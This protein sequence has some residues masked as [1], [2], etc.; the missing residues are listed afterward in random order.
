MPINKLQIQTLK[1]GLMVAGIKE[2]YILK[3]ANIEDLQNLEQDRY[4]D[5]LC[6]L[7]GVARRDREAPEDARIL[8]TTGENHE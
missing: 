8:S 5:C 7:M 6:W 3:R 2:E 1:R 4:I